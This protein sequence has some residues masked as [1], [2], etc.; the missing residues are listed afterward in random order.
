MISPAERLD[1]GAVTAADTVRGLLPERRPSEN[2]DALSMVL[3]CQK[4]NRMTSATIDDKELRISV[5]WTPM[6]LDTTNCTPAKARPQVST[7]GQISRTP[8]KPDAMTTK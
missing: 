8:P 1:V 5:S 2:S 3:G 6:K 7:A 4:R